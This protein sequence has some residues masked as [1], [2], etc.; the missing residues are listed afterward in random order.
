LAQGAGVETPTDHDQSKLVGFGDTLTGDER[1]RDLDAVVQAVQG[2]QP[3]AAPT[4]LAGAGVVVATLTPAELAG[5]PQVQAIRP[6]RTH[7]PRT[8]GR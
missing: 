1:A 4:V 2:F 7:R 6:N 5:L 3:D 8:A